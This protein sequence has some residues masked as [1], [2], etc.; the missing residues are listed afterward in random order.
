LVTD[1]NVV[2]TGEDGAIGILAGLNKGNLANCHVQGDVRGDRYIGG[3]AGVHAGSATMTRCLAD[4]TI[5]TGDGIYVGGLVGVCRDATFSE[6][7][8]VATILGDDYL[9]ATGGLAGDV[10]R[11]TIIR[12]FALG[13]IR[14]GTGTWHLGGLVGNLAYGEILDCYAGVD[15]VTGIKAR[16]IGGL[17]GD[18]FEGN[19]VD[20]YSRGGIAVGAE[21]A[22]IG[23][24]SGFG[25]IP[26]GNFWDRQTSGLDRNFGGTGLTTVE[27]QRTATFTDAGWDFVGET[28]NGTADIWTICEG[29]DYPRLAWEQVACE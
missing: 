29:K 27:M 12:C 20:C 17:L 24:L 6:C 25:A 8:A 11:G 13:Q 7:C 2:G 23:G 26:A 28:A 4:V 1:A 18:I 5:R 15:I 16:R 9:Q 14:G 10:A 22:E 19:V 3:L 21:S